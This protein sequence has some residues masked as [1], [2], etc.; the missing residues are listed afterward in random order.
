MTVLRCVFATISGVPASVSREWDVFEITAAGAAGARSHHSARPDVANKA[1]SL[2]VSPGFSGPTGG[3]IPQPGKRGDS[4]KQA[5]LIAAVAEHSG[6]T[7]KA[8]S[9]VLAGVAEVAQAAL[10]KGD[11]VALPHLGK[12]KP[13]VRAAR[14][15]RNPKTGEAVKVPAKTRVKFVVAKDLRDA[16][17]KPKAWK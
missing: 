1:P 9:D 15:A 7:A 17:P 3:A 16:M 6:L 8:V 10:A 13:V 2:P 11:E 12:L 5:E 4:V 14:N